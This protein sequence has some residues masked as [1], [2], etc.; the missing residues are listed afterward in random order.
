[1]SRVSKK[2]KNLIKGAMRRIF[3]RSELRNKVADSVSV[4]NH[5]E[6]TRPRV[7]KW[8][9]CPVCT[10][11]TPTYLIQIDHKEPIIPLDSEISKMTL[12]EIA[13][14]IWCEESN[15]QAICKSCHEIKTTAEMAIRKANKAKNKAKKD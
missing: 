14:R 13:E 7:T 12:D 15:L 1:M 8:S 5:Y 10:E 11:L 9:R 4:P 6:P 2:D 3:S